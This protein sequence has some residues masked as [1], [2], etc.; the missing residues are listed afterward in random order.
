MNNP[1]T[2]VFVVSDCRGGYS[3][4]N[5]NR[6]EPALNDGSRRSRTSLVPA[7][8]ASISPAPQVAIHHED[9]VSG[10]KLPTDR[11]SPSS[12]CLVLTPQTAT[13][14]PPERT[15]AYA[16]TPRDQEH[17]TIL[18]ML[19]LDP[20]QERQSSCWQD[21]NSGHN[22]DLF[23]QAGENPSDQELLVKK[24]NTSPISVVMEISGLGNFPDPLEK[25]EVEFLM[26]NSSS[27][28]SSSSPQSSEKKALLRL[29]CY[30]T[31]ASNCIPL[32]ALPNL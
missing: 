32:H 4:Q 20:Y 26:L 16:H 24:C 10:L 2:D 6:R 7:A 19:P 27:S 25:H 28:T 1:H 11:A 30:H 12:P 9:M 15:P 14:R 31:A 21:N 23:V 8:L 22:I 3:E 18:A 17:D 5:T 13:S 29:D